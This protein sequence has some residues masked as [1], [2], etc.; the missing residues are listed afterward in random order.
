MIIFL[1][2]AFFKVKKKNMTGTWGLDN[3]SRLLI[4]ID[5]ITIFLELN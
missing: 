2:E 4:T 3:K 1:Y 5:E